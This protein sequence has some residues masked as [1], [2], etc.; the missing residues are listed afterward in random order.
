[1]EVLGRAMAEHKNRNGSLFSIN[2]TVY[3]LNLPTDSGF[4]NKHRITGCTH[5]RL[6]GA[7]D[8]SLCSLPSAFPSGTPFSSRSN[9]SVVFFIV[10]CSL[11]L[12][13]PVRAD[14]WGETVGINLAQRC[15]QPVQGQRINNILSRVWCCRPVISAF[16]RQKQGDR[17]SK[18]ILGYRMS[19]RPT[20]DTYILNMSFNRS[21][22]KPSLQ[23]GWWMSV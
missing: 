16:G 18:V 14:C 3:I 2:P 4:Q 10:F 1:M 5:S 15:W 11:C 12:E 17:K 6:Q 7:G 8:S 22:H 21:A 20:L 19:S 9:Q 23:I 13:S